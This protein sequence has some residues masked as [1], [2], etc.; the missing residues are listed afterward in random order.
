MALA[1][2]NL[3]VMACR[4]LS[5]HTIDTRQTA[6]IAADHGMRAARMGVAI[7]IEAYENQLI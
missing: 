6:T 1:L 5:R 3:H 2:V 4:M 7:S